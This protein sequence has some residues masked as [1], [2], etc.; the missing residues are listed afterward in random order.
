MIQF[1]SNLIIF[2]YRRQF[3]NSSAEK[4]SRARLKLL[5]SSFRD[6]NLD[7]D[8]LKDVEV[9]NEDNGNS[10]EIELYQNNSNEHEDYPQLE[11]ESVAKDEE[12]GKLPMPP[13]DVASGR[14]AGIVKSGKRMKPFYFT[15]PILFSRLFQCLIRDHHATISRIKQPILLAL[16]LACFYAPIGNDQASVQN[17][18]GILYQLNAY[19]FVGLL[20]CVEIFPSQRNIF[21]REYYDQSYSSIAF[22]FT[23]FCMEIPMMILTSIIVA[24]I[25]VFGIG[26]ASTGSA[27]LQFSFVIFTFVFTGQCLG[28]V[29]CLAFHHIGFS[30]SLVSAI[31]GFLCKFA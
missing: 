22:L 8:Y 16:I 4:E 27:F 28:V 14:T 13:S 5:I 11:S 21:Y 25:I 17:R 12:K 29:F 30:L 6:R 10:R 15:I 9:S 2:F 20:S 23:Y 26:L 24:I 18:I 1:V 3:R 7:Q 19:T 31:I